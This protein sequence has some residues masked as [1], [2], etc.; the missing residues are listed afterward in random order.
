MP[1]VYT[2]HALRFNALLRQA[3]ADFGVNLIEVSHLGP[4]TAILLK[5]KI[6]QG[7]LVVIVGD[8]TPPAESGSTRVD[9]ID[10]LGAAGA[11]RARP[12]HPGEPAR[13]PG[14]SLLL[15]CAP[16]LAIVPPTPAS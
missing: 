4:D 8:R 13:L 6:D 12:V 7:E 16:A 14:L 1:V 9:R 10:F 11:L 3:N 5:E 2:E 15:P